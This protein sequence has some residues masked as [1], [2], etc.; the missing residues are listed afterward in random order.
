MLNDIQLSK[1]TLYRR[2]SNPEKHLKKCSTS[3]PITEM[4]IQTILRYHLIPVKIA[5]IIKTGDSSCTTGCRAWDHI[6]DR[7]ANF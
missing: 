2:I 1:R 4:Q 6:S 3:L 5:K 7:N